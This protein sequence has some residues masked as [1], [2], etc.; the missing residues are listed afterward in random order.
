MVASGSGGEGR[1]RTRLLAQALEIEE[2]M[3]ER[4][5]EGKTG[6][7]EERG[8][9]QRH[10]KE[11]PRG[12]RLWGEGKGWAPEAG[13]PRLPCAAPGSGSHTKMQTE[14]PKP[15]HTR[16]PGWQGKARGR[17]HTDGPQTTQCGAR[18][19]SQKR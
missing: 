8:Q 13:S 1:G 15:R 4:G 17:V 16:G 2:M 6:T 14:H 7:G 19:A 12:R 18:M 10:N 9:S 11:R 5:A 3:T